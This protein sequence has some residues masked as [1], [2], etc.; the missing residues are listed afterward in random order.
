VDRR[1]EATAVIAIANGLRHSA[2]KAISNRIAR[3]LSVWVPISLGD[4]ADGRGFHPICRPWHYWSAFRVEGGQS[5]C[6]LV[7]LTGEPR[8]GPALGFDRRSG[9]VGP[10]PLALPRSWFQLA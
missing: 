3:S 1:A 4:V 10:V 2:I 8:T 6:R 9:G 7:S 5:S